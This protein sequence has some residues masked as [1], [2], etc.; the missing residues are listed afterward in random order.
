MRRALDVVVGGVPLFS[1]VQSTWNLLEPSVG[2]AL[3]EAAGAG[4]TVVVKE[5]VANGR[6]APGADDP[7]PA[8]QA[9]LALAAERGVGVD[10]VA[11]AAALAQPWATR[12]LSGAV[13]PEQVRSNV[14]AQDVTLDAADLH[15]LLARPEEAPTYWSE[16][17]ERAWA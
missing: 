3:A 6:L 1:V 4:L 15:R 5:G 7:A 10:Q 14:A 16:R 9:A 12:V 17:S 13:T 11:L 2:P 8:V